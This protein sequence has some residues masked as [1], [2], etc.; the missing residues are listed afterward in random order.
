MSGRVCLRRQGDH[1]M[2][3]SFKGRR[4]DQRLIT[5]QGRYTSDWNLAGQLHAFFLRSDRAHAEIATL[6]VQPALDSPGVIAVF[7][8]A[9]TAQAGFKSAPPLVKYPGKG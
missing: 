1:C 6:N 2:S 7:T 8:G 9:D 5:G 3:T 4:E